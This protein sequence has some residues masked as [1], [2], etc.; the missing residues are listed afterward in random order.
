MS[1]VGNVTLIRETYRFFLQHTDASCAAFQDAAAASTSADGVRPQ[2][3]SVNLTSV[4][5]NC[6]RSIT[7]MY[8]GLYES[9]ALLESS[10]GI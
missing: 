1:L 4:L 10:D 5:I 8:T 3:T 9:I 6:A 7:P 2:V